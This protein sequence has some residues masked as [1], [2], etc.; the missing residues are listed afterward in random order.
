ME[1]PSLVILKEE[2]RPFKGKKILKASGYADIGLKRLTGKP[3]KDFKTWGK[4]FLVELPGFSLRIH[5]LL[6]GFYYINEKKNPNPKLSLTF[7]NG[8]LHCYLS[9]VRII[10]EPLK[11]VFDWEVDLL[12]PKWNFKK[13]RKLFLQHPDAMVCD[14]VLDPDIFSGSGNIIKNEALY[15]AGIHPETRVKHLPPRKVSQLVRAVHA[16]SY[17]FLRATK[18]DKLVSTWKVYDRKTCA[19]CEGKVIKKFTGR[20]Q[21]NSFIC[22]NCQV[23]YKKQ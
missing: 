13:V 6:F 11:N 7:S 18:K 21:R 19:V 14:V 4:L 5:F 9:S 10:E 17:E 23:L 15:R 8:S 22:R 1:G 2:V 16:Y 12:S 20:L 3:I